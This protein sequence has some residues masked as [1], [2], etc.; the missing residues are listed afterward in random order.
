MSFYGWR[1]YVPVA[2]RRRKA[3]RELAKLKKKGQSSAPVTIEG[4]TIATSFWGK[5]WCTN[6]ERYSDYANRLPRGRT[7]VRNG[8]V[9]DLQ[10]A[11]GEVAALVAGSSL[12]RIKIRIAPVKPSRWKSM[13]RDCAG[14]VDSLV[15]LLQGRFE[16]GVMDRVCRRGTGCFQYRERSSCP[17]PVRTGPICASTW[18]RCFMVLAPGSTTRRSSSSCSAASMRTSS[19]RAPGVVSPCPRRR[20]AAPKCLTRATSRRCSGWKWTIPPRPAPARRMPR[21]LRDSLSGRKPENRQRAR[22]P[23]RHPPTLRSKIRGSE[24]CRTQ[25]RGHAVLRLPFRRHQIHRRKIFAPQ[26]LEGQGDRGIPG[27]PA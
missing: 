4:R 12:Y 23:V 18:P 21:S 17:A 26:V 22:N 27:R 16:K 15:E 3:E 2:E 24:F 9:V 1:P 20:L 25:I 5:S 10:I 7:Y 13:C 11:K 6:L 19:S 8:S 14:S